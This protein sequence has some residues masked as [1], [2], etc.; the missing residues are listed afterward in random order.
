MSLLVA[1]RYQKKEKTLV[2]H[3]A[4]ATLPKALPCGVL[5]ERA[6]RRWMRIGFGEALEMLECAGMVGGLD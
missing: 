6:D 3:E 4:V 2:R 5:D 1:R